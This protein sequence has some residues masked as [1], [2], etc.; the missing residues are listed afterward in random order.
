MEVIDIPNV[1]P[2]ALDLGER[3]NSYF[4]A[5]GGKPNWEPLET[6][7]FIRLLSEGPRV[8][9]IGA[10][11]GWF[12]S[13]G[14]KL[15]APAGRFYAFEPD[16]DNFASLINNLSFHRLFNVVPLRIALG[17]EDREGQLF[18]SHENLG[19]HRIN[20]VDGR[21]A[22]T[23][24]IARLDTVLQGSDFVP[25]LIKIDVQG[26]ETVAFEGGRSVIERAGKTCAKLIEFWPGGMQGGVPEA[27]ALASR[28]FEW[29]QPVFVCHHEDAGSIR[30]V[31]LDTL[32]SAINGCIHP[33][34]PSY[35]DL[36]VAPDDNRMHRLR[37]YIGPA[38]QPW[39]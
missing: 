27:T 20:P 38:W 10:N 30:P 17:D 22:I 9:D 18:L 4:T 8:L 7:L 31:D 33:S 35:L 12:T 16:P 39:E 23:I 13:I 28:I 11:V 6:Q 25:D 29:K 5:N 19:D 21:Q 15:A 2:M 24:Q 32:C 26:A 34:K 37:D 36:L 1:P 3:A 14:A